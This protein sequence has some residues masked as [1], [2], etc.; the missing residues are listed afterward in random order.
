MVTLIWLSVRSEVKVAQSCL[1]LCNSMNCSLPG[2]SV[3]G[4]LQTRILQW[5]AIP[6]S[7]GF[8]QPRDRT[9][10]SHIVGRFFTVWATGEVISQNRIKL[11]FLYDNLLVCFSVV[12]FSSSLIMTVLILL[13]RFLLHKVMIFKYRSINTI[14]NDC[15][16]F[17][18]MF[19]VFLQVYRAGVSKLF[20]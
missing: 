9:Q 1:A 15:F 8:S 11:I 5:V 18:I 19:W 3:H 7:R 4:I 14:M 16:I 6:F 12:L 13:T 10:V 2:F 20:L 17:Q